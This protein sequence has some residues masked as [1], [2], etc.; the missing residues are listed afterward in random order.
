M[1]G[2]GSSASLPHGDTGGMRAGAAPAHGASDE[3]KDAGR[4]KGGGTK[5]GGDEDE[6]GE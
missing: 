2:Q 3:R 1:P 4:P 5:T 6:M